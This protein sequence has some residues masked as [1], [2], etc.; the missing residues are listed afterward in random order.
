MK[1]LKQIEE[2]VSDYGHFGKNS[3]EAA[4][5]DM[6]ADLANMGSA[7]MTYNWDMD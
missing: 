7:A 4:S 6:L 2:M 1:N 3:V 5:Y